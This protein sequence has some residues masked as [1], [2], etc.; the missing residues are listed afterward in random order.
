MGTLI[1]ATFEIGPPGG[2]AALAVQVGPGMDGA[3]AEVQTRLVADEGGRAVLD[4]PESNWGANVPLLVS[5]LVAGMEVPGFDRC[6]PVGLERPDGW[7]PGPAF[8]AVGH[9]L[10]VGVIV[11][12]R[13]T[14]GVAATVEA[15]AR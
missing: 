2:A 6:R 8:G 5:G 3:P 1:R 15:L 9:G 10:T 11:K 12:P 4:L 14:A 7:L 13:L